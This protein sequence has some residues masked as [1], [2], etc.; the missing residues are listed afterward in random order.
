VEG[1]DLV[2]AKHWKQEELQLRS[3]LTALQGRL[4]QR[5]SELMIME[6]VATMMRTA[7]SDSVSGVLPIVQ[8]L[9][10]TGILTPANVAISNNNQN[11]SS[12]SNSHSNGRSNSASISNSIS[13]NRSLFVRIQQVEC[14]LDLRPASDAGLVSRIE[15]AEVSLLGSEGRTGGSAVQ[16]LSALENELTL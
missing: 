12:N 16:R 13:I 14:S 6:R 1:V 4:D 2:Q 3:Q 8:A 5:P 11:P 7:S 15:A 10:G 9:T